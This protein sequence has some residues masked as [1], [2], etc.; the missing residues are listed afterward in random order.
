MTAKIL[1][2]TRYSQIDKSG[3][4]LQEVKLLTGLGMEDDFHQGGKRQLCLLT[5]EIRQW[6]E[7]RVQKGLCFGRFKENILIQGMPEG[8]LAPDTGLRVG[9]AILWTD[10]RRKTCHSG[11]GL[12]LQGTRC[13]LS[14]CAVFAAVARGGLVR[15]GDSVSV[16][17][18]DFAQ[19]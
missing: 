3:E 19:S 7:G 2:L 11:C 10:K 1:A 9:E 16:V 14:E 15:I 4:T 17:S 13:L 6:M 12:F 5:A 18:S 8:N